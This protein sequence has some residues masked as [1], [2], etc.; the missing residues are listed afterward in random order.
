MSNKNDIYY[1]KYLKYK[2]KYLDLKRQL[3]GQPPEAE[4][5]RLTTEIERISDESK[6]LTTE[7]QR[8]TIERNTHS[9][10]PNVRLESKDELAE[11][12]FNSL[13]EDLKKLFPIKE[14]ERAQPAQAYRTSLLQQLGEYHKA[15]YAR[16]N[17]LIERATAEYDRLNALRQITIRDRNEL[18]KRIVDSI[19]WILAE[20]D[21]LAAETHRLAAERDTHQLPPVPRPVR[22]RETGQQYFNSLPVAIQIRFPIDPTH[23]TVNGY[24]YR[25]SMMTRRERIQEEYK[26]LNALK[27]AANAARDELIKRLEKLAMPVTHNSE[28]RVARDPI[29][30]EWEPITWKTDC[31]SGL[32][33]PRSACLFKH[34]EG[35]MPTHNVKCKVK[36]CK[37]VKCPFKHSI[38]NREKA[39]ADATKATA[40]ATAAISAE[41]SLLG[42]RSKVVVK[43]RT[44]AQLG[45]ERFMQLIETATALDDFGIGMDRKRRTSYKEKGPAAE[46]FC[47]LKLL[48]RNFLTSGNQLHGLTL[49]GDPIEIT[50]AP[51]RDHRIMEQLKAN[52]VVLLEQGK[53]E[54]ECVFT[55]SNLEELHRNLKRFETNEFDV[56]ASGAFVEYINF[57]AFF[58]DVPDSQKSR[59]SPKSREKQ[60]LPLPLPYDE[61]E[62]EEEVLEPIEEAKK[63]APQAEQQCR[64]IDDASKAELASGKEPTKI[65][66]INTAMQRNLERIKALLA[67]EASREPGT[68]VLTLEE[69]NV[70]GR[71]IIKLQDAI[72][73]AHISIFSPEQVLRKQRNKEEEGL[74]GFIEHFKKSLAE[75]Y[76]KVSDPRIQEAETSKMLAEYNSVLE[77]PE[78]KRDLENTTHK[79]QIKKDIEDLLKELKSNPREMAEAYVRLIGFLDNYE[80]RAAQAPTAEHKQR[81]LEEFRTRNTNSGY[82]TDLSKITKSDELR[83]IQEKIRKIELSLL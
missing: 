17:A 28:G 49:R 67:Q 81:L 74:R 14:A 32:E 68:P 83:Q 63:R 64:A 19:P 66:K 5:G 45:M 72:K 23:R 3:G 11:A 38:E 55:A 57:D 37:D 1:S 71:E 61:Y 69:R 13:S 4:V 12:F 35:W 77:N 40:L 6:R 54:R 43:S 42:E 20:I 9:T 22:E 76:S 70:I 2:N 30:G 56:D 48:P 51:K 24:R 26:R 73:Q 33:C 78:F 58:R 31:H 34:P 16:L 80:L 59:Q 65:Q 47:V 53:L 18:K 25:D 79:K 10:T 60:E 7:I 8:L 39:V 29:T 21:R 36:D 46:G 27:D 15:E 62:S 44:A 52:M 50:V 41:S 82:L 75:L